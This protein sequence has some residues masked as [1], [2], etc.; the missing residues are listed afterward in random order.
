M[1]DRMTVQPADAAPAEDQQ[2]EEIARMIYSEINR[3]MD[4]EFLST[5]AVIEAGGLRHVLIEG[6]IDL[7]RVATALAR[8]LGLSIPEVE[9]VPEN[10]E[11]AAPFKRIGS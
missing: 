8:R 1:D 10:A 6:H 11:L 4:S 2:I 9:T 3:Q 5:S 7:I